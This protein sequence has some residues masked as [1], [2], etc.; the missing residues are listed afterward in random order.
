MKVNHAVGLWREAAG[1]SRLNTYIRVI[2]MV[3]RP[4]ILE[5][6]GIKSKEIWTESKAKNFGILD[7]TRRK[8]VFHKREYSYVLR[9]TNGKYPDSRK[10]RK[11]ERI[12]RA[13]ASVDDD[14]TIQDPLNTVDTRFGSDLNR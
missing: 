9:T 2:Q 5:R 6:A 4:E 8:G 1:G 13:W 7:Q 3:V 10:R 12:K 11:G 14:W